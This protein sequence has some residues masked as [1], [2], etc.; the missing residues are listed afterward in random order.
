MM[1]DE[2]LMG[3]DP[4][5]GTTGWGIIRSTGR[6][7][8][9]VDSG[10]ISTSPSLPM[11]ERLRKL[12]VHLQET[13]KQHH[14]VQCAVESGFVGKSPQSAL[15]LGQARA[16]AIL[17]IETL[18]IP[19]V[20]LAP[21]EIKIALTG[22]GAAAKEQVGYIV[23]KMLGLEFDANEEDISDALAAAICC[24]MH[25]TRNPLKAIVG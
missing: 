10:K 5:L 16:A 15:K 22:R 6:N 1:A 11:G 19:V 18:N 2:I 24:A 12:F 14:I 9:Y 21:R 23:G 3:I 17:A 7:F 25:R 8:V 13:A 20:D 4:G